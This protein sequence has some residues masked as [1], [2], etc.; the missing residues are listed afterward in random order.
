MFNLLQAKL[1]TLLFI[2]TCILFVCFSKLPVRS[3]L[4]KDNKISEFNSKHHQHLISSFIDCKEEIYFSEQVETETESNETLAYNN[5]LC[6]NLSKYASDNSFL[7]HPIWK[8]KTKRKVPI[9]VLNL[10]MKSFLS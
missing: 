7:F 2:G 5:Y 4:N 6:K 10:Q 1:K 3:S 9:Y 8:Y